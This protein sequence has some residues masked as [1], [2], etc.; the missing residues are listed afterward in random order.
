[1][2]SI[3]A[4]NSTVRT[5]TNTMP[6]G[7]SGLTA[8]SRATLAAPVAPAASAAATPP[9]ASKIAV[10][11]PVTSTPQLSL[12]AI[13]TLQ[14]ARSGE[15]TKETITKALN[16]YGANR[17][18][19]QDAPASDTD[20]RKPAASTSR[21]TLAELNW[22]GTSLVNLQTRTPIGTNTLSLANQF[23]QSLLK[24]LSA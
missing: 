12:G 1:M 4:S 22:E 8:A 2:T 16:G 14:D 21:L 19:L 11:S 18:T 9:S 3:T 20:V 5:L 13:L 10:T 15:L 7:L 23:P 6:Q 24:L 17:P